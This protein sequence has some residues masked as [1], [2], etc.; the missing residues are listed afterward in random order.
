MKV[1]ASEGRFRL[2]FGDKER[3]FFI[4]LFVLIENMLLEEHLT[5][6]EHTA[7]F[8]EDIHKAEAM[9]AP[10]RTRGSVV[11]EYSLEEV[12]ILEVVDVALKSSYFEGRFKLLLGLDE[13]YAETLLEQLNE[14]KSAAKWRT[15]AS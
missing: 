8:G 12:E 5:V 9:I 15:R 13:R 3:L 11:L 7:I 2:E 4:R 1:E 10:F 14:A 6:E